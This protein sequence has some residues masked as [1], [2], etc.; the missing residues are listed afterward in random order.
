MWANITWGRNSRHDTL[1]MAGDSDSTDAPAGL[2]AVNFTRCHAR[3]RAGWAGWQGDH[4]VVPTTPPRVSP[5]NTLGNATAS[6]LLQHSS[7]L[8]R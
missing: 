1:F 3:W 2:H 8:Q 5:Y 6:Q 4:L 7:G